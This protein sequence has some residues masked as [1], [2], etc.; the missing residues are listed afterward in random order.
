MVLISRI[1]L[2]VLLF[3]LNACFLQSQNQDVVSW[4]ASKS[5]PF[6]SVYDLDELIAS[7]SDRKLVLM[8]EASHGTHEYYH[9]RGEMTRQLITDHGFDFIVVEGDWASIYRLNKYVKDLPGAH[10]SAYDVLKSF[11]RWPQWMWANKDI[12]ELAEWLRSYND[13]LPSDEKVGIYGMDV[14]GQW[15]AM[16]DLMDFVNTNMPEDARVIENYLNCFSGY[17]DNEWNYARAVAQ[18]AAAC[19]DMLQRVVEIV[20][21]YNNDLSTAH[22][23]HFRARQNA[24]VVKNAEDFYRLAVTSSVDSWNSRVNHFWLTVH[25]LLSFHGVD[26]KGIVWAHNTHVGDARATTMAAQNQQNIGQLSRTDLGGDQV[27]IIGFG[28]KKGT[29]NA[30]SEWE[31]RMQIMKI[32]EAME[33]S[34]DNYLGRVKYDQ[35]YLLFNEADR[36]NPF[37]Q[38]PLGH[39]AIGVVYN[40][41]QEQGNYVPT[42]P[43]HRYDAL[44]FFQETKAL[45]L[46]K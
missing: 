40:P 13:A 1:L 36:T 45:E 23:A 28:T 33:G 14:Y 46:V 27:F 17:G 38:T 42:L 32:P 25:R 22:K 43:A 37:M 19:D 34:L 20:E 9:W 2:L 44:I 8:G 31:S 30:G 12:L 39:R 21:S 24:L 29:V 7:A 18:G 41:R 26:S 4:L 10:V 3:F 15:Q 35:F 16:D 11:D 5:K 6:N